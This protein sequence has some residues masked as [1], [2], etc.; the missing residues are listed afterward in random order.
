VKGSSAHACET[1]QS[2]DWFRAVCR[3][4]SATGKVTSAKATK[5]FDEKQGYVVVGQGSLVLVTRYTRG[6]DQAFEIAWERKAAE[7]QLRWP[8]ASTNPPN[9]RGELVAK[10]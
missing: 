9:V 1:K 7:L 8:E 4:N 10:P 2:G 5:G 6:T 3:A